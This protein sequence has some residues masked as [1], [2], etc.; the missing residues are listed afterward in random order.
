MNKKRKEDIEFYQK[1]PVLYEEKL[2]AKY[3]KEHVNMFV[4]YYNEPFPN[5]TELAATFSLHLSTIAAILV[6]QM[7]YLR[8]LQIG[9]GTKRREINPLTQEEFDMA[10]ELL[11]RGETRTEIARTIKRSKDLMVYIDRAKSLQEYRELRREAVYKQRHKHDPVKEYAQIVGATGIPPTD[12]Q[13]LP[14]RYID[15]QAFREHLDSFLLTF[16]AEE[17]QKTNANIIAENA[18]LRA[19][20]ESLKAR[21]EKGFAQMALDHLQQRIKEETE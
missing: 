11:F 18:E 12:S 21:G 7:K 16:I 5:I 3:R 17:V 10:K 14:K 6:R 4:A 19:E 15:L 1:N 9:E 2:R 13:T 8:G 20:N